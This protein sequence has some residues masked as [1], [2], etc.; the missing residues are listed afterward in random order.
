MPSIDP[1]TGKRFSGARQQRH[2]RERAALLSGDA[3]RPRRQNTQA[4]TAPKSVQPATVAD[5]Q[6]PIPDNFADVTPPPI[7]E[8]VAAVEAWAADLNLRSAVAAETASAAEQV[9]LA[10]VGSILQQA[11]KVRIRAE[12]SEK[13][14]K[15]RRLRLFEG[16]ALSLDRPPVG[17]PVAIPAWA[18]VK[19]AALA[20]AAATDPGWLPDERLVV[21][22]KSLAGAALLPCRGEQ[23]RIVDAVK[24]QG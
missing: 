21:T 5:V 20:H 11:A 24:A 18:F 3:K 8:G 4:L 10:A 16:E 2:K 15:L 9:R 19:L 14:C 1:T 6:L 13:V 23:R 22:M 12:T 17:D 7:S